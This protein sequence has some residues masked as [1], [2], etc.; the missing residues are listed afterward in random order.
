[1]EDLFLRKFNSYKDFK[2]QFIEWQDQNFQLI[3]I[4]KSDKL[5]PKLFSE[6]TVA[7][8]E[9]E[10]VIFQCK[11]GGKPRDGKKLEPTND[12]ARNNTHSACLNCPWK[13]IPRFNKTENCLKFTTTELN[14]DNHAV[15]KEIYQAYTEVITRKLEQQQEA[16]AVQKT[17][18]QA[19]STNFNQV[20]TLNEQF[21]FNMSAKDLQNYKHK[22]KSPHLKP[23]SFGKKLNLYCKVIP[24]ALKFTKIL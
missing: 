9:Y 2:K 4:S 18:D 1:M 20:T 10:R 24:T 22:N 5:N 16:I 7:R 8:F 15:S 19:R 3:T 11:H 23:S 17:L 12:K 6:A 21:D 14:H 13:A